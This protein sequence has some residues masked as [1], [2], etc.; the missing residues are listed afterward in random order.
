VSLR[1]AI[2]PIPR[3]MPA[4]GDLVHLFI[5]GLFRIWVCIC[6][7]MTVKRVGPRAWGPVIY[8]ANHRAFLDPPMVG[9]WSPVPVSYFA[10]ASLW[11]NPLIGAVLT[12]GK[13]IPVERENPGI[14]SMKGAIDR[15][16]AGV[17]IMVFPEGTRTRTGRL[18]RFKDGPALFARRSGVPIIPV[19]VVRTERCWPRESPLPHL[20]GSRLEVRF[21]SPMVAPP[22]LAP[23]AQDAWLSRRLEAWIRL[24]ERR[25][26]GK[27][28]G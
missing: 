6:Y 11:K 17:P 16:R 7:R 28:A 21:G 24:Q 1:E 19:Y 4:V 10:R 13:S 9:M 5:G 2:N 20:F 15:L 22:E 25:C 26:L 23:R 12:S 3:G 8:A 27:A 14:S 18:G